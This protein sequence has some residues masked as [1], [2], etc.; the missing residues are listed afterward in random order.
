MRVTV[1]EYNKTTA[2]IIAAIAQAINAPAQDAEYEMAEKEWIK[3]IHKRRFQ[4]FDELRYFMS[5]QNI[6]HEGIYSPDEF[7]IGDELD[8]DYVNAI[9][10]LE[11]EISQ[12]LARSRKIKKVRHHL[13]GVAQSYIK[14]YFDYS[15]VL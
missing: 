12:I 7:T 5:Y 8:A 14:L 15:R 1:K 4:L 3:E 10:S 9:M 11:S 13:A 6:S 2:G